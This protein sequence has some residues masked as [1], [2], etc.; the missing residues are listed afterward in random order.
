MH[1]PRRHL[2]FLDFETYYDNESYTLR[3]MTPAEY[4]L[5]P[6]FE[7]ILCA[8]KADNGPHEII[9]GPDFPKWLSQFDPTITTTVT[10]NSLFD[11][12][13]LAWQ[14]EFVP[15]T[16]IDAMAMARA[17]DGHLLSR[18]NLATLSEHIGIPAKGHTINNVAGMR[19]ADIMAQ[20][21]LWQDY[22]QYA[23]RDNMNCE[24]LFLHYYPRMPWS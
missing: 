11:N 8:V 12:A 15:D 24:Q 6:R 23:L 2:L 5:D 13:I 22:K 9:D 7:M 19:R 14:Y 17:L 16:M 18:F 10:F 3:K 1:A 20:P 21:Q 4:I